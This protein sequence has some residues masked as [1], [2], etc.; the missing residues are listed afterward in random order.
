MNINF[1]Y[2]QYYV[3]C[4]GNKLVIAVSKFGASAAVHNRVC[5]TAKDIFNLLEIQVP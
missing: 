5:F 4:F 1:R 2:G 3:L